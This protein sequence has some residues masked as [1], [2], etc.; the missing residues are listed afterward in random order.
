[1]FSYFP[2]SNILVFCSVDKYFIADF[3]LLLSKIF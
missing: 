1:M 3:V 2:L